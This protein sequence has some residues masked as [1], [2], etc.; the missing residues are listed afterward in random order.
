MAM[1]AMAERNPV[2][3][4]VA[5]R[6]GPPTA[7]LYAYVNGEGTPLKSVAMICDVVRKKLFL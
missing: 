7:T 2:A 6:L 5:K 1:T 3:K 4:D